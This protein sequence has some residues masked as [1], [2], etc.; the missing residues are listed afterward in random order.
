MT[1]R[2]PADRGDA[3][4]TTEPTRQTQAERRETAERAILEAAAII[5]AER[6][7]EELTL[8]EAGEAAGYSRALPAHYYGTKSALLEAL[9]SHIM[10]GY[11]ERMRTASMAGEGLERLCSVIEFAIDDVLSNPTP[12]RAYQTIMAAGLNR[13]ELRPT[14]ERITRQGIDDFAALIAQGRAKGE[15]RADVR[16]RAD[17]SIILAS[18][19]G[20]IFQW[21]IIPDHVSLS[22]MR[23]NLVT[24][25]RNSLKA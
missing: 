13:P 14:V 11:V 10:A 6:G 24:N 2:K 23:D 18:L 21:L 16:A 4:A 8:N 22:H 19:R 7:L 15:I 12:A 25:V 17:A 20:V 3:L 5:V 1:I 9:A